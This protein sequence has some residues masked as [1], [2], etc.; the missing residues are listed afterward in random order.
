MA[1]ASKILRL[2]VSGPLY[3][4]ERF[5]WSIQ[6]RPITDPGWLQP[7]TVPAGVL[8]AVSAFH[9]TTN[10]ISAA[11]KV[12]NIKLNVIKED[13][14]YL[15]DTNTVEAFP[16]PYAGGIANSIPPQLALAIT[17]ATDAQRGLASKGRFFVPAIAYLPASSTDPLISTANATSATTAATT[18]INALN[19]ALSP[20]GWRAAVC[21]F[22]GV[23]GVGVNRD[24]TKVRTGRVID[25]IRS[26]RRNFAETYF[27]GAT[28]A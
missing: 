20:T 23:S 13:G 17:L 1:Y 6:F 10:M 8:S 16:T 15:D 22:G 18:M 24:I 5:S 9:Q 27:D 7:D 25:T 11:A 26:R 28:L 12:D 14:H 21:S 4:T 19:T 3:L 2:V